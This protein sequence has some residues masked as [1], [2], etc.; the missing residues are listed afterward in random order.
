MFSFSFKHE[1]FKTQ[2][3]SA[4]VLLKIIFH[5]K[6]V[7]P[8]SICACKITK[9]NNFGRRNTEKLWK[10]NTKNKHVR[11]TDI[12]KSKVETF[13]YC[14]HLVMCVEHR[15]SAY[16]RISRVVSAM[17]ELGEINRF[18]ITFFK[19]LSS[20]GK[21]VTALRETINSGWFC[22]EVSAWK[23]RMRET[24]NR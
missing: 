16:F 1:Y 5:H 10:Q 15:R 6:I 22:S 2:L 13:V 4:F 21:S 11:V 24:V 20:R 3:N 7:V 14:F 17:H 8:F 23:D 12:N 19:L 18:G 9:R